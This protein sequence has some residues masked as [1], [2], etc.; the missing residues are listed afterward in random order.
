[1]NRREFLHKL[2]KPAIAL[3]AVPA[4]AVAAADRG[5]QAIDPHLQALKS[6]F[7]HMNDRMDRMERSQKRM[8]KAL[9]ALTAVSLGF[10]VSPLI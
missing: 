8:L 9:F 2:K 7:E 10:D 1:M 6:K 5:R 3:A 4:I